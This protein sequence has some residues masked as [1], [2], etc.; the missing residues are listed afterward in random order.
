MNFLSQSFLIGPLLIALT[1]TAGAEPFAQTTLPVKVVTPRLP[2]N[3]PAAAQEIAS[4]APR[5]KAILDAYHNTAPVRGDRFIRVVYWTPSDRE[6]VP[7]YRERLSKIMFDIQN[8]FAFEMN[9]NGFGPLTFDLEKEAD[10]LLKIYVARAP[11]PRSEYSRE[12]SSSVIREES[13]AALKQA[14]IDGDKETVLIFQNL[15]NWDEKTRTMTG[16]YPYNGGG[17]TRSGSAVQVDSH[18]LALDFLSDI[19]EANKVHN[20]E[21]GHINLAHYN[22]IFIGGIAHELGHALSMPHNKE[23]S[24]Q[25]AWGLSLMGAGNRT[26]GEDL[27]TES[28]R[29]SKGRGSFLVLADALRMASHP[30]FSNSLKGFDGKPNAVFSD[31]KLTTDGKNLRYAAR[32]KAD[33]P[34]YAVLGYFDPEGGGDY[35][36][37]TATAVPDADG[38]FSFTCS[39]ADLVAGKEAQLRVVALQV[40]GATAWGTNIG[41]VFLRRRLQTARWI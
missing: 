38:N 26:Y 34:V 30:S 24:D 33:P 29:E 25:A 20:S 19:S 17:S 22:S 10:G 40:N 23:R 4:Q 28:V 35:D 7:G 12:K 2:S 39:S 8:F 31:V 9:R 6:P 1:L 36:A 14:G 37:R 41:L 15:V 21:Y 27:R 5:A 16:D 32:V 11:K 3:A 13:K 18:V